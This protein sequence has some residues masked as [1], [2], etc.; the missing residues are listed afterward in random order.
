MFAAALP[1]QVLQAR[2]YRFPHLDPGCVA[3]ER[4]R[5]DTLSDEDC[6]IRALLPFDGK[7]ASPDMVFRRH[8]PSVSGRHHDAE[9]DA[10]LHYFALP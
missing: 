10:F 6:R 7:R 9:R 1:R 3:L 4:E 2:R 5:A 8:R